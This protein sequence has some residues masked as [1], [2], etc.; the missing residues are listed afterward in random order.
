MRF[1]RSLALCLTRVLLGA[2]LRPEA[3]ASTQRFRMY[4][5]VAE[6]LEEVA[7]RSEALAHRAKPLSRVIPAR[8]RSYALADD[9]VFAFSQPVNSSFAQLAGSRAVG[10]RRWGSITFSEM[11]RLERLFQ[12]QLEVTVFV[13]L[14]D[15][16]N[17]GHAEA[18]QL[19]AFR[20]CSTRPCPPCLLPCHARLVLLLQVLALFGPSVGTVCWLIPPFQS[21]RLRNAP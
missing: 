16:W 6:V 7:A 3:T 11:E 19:S 14:A 21:L 10:S 18:R 12:N 17:T 20:P 2:V 1:A 5:R 15:V 9:A 13:P 4:P 8:A